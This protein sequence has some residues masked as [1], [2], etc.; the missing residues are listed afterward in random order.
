MNLSTRQTRALG[1]VMHLLTEATDGDAL[2]ESLGLPL[3]DLL[4]ADTYVSMVWNGDER[5]FERMH[6]LNMSAENL[7]A[8]GEY[9]RF[10]D[11]IT[12][13]LMERRRPTLAQQVMPQHELVRTEFFNDFLLRD[14]CYWG[15]N[16]YFYDRDACVGDFR[17][18]R[19]RAR[20]TFGQNELEVLRML[21][22][23]I[24]CTLA[25]LHWRTSQAPASLATEKAEEVLQRKG[26]LSGR[27]AQVAWLV[28]CGCPDKEIC[29]RLGLGYPTVRFHLSNAF[30]KL[31]A[32]NRTALAGRVKAM[33]DD[34][35]AAL[36]G[37]SGTVLA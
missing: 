27:E 15:L 26:R 35:A 22:P 34:R 18:W 23:A 13:P 7:R 2:R 4:D 32:P 30:H 20:G 29:Q 9:F 1:D 21:E 28:S 31:R 10:I 33:L 17:I 6:A 8:W 3:L 14:R 36:A 12:F 37:G 5:C 16:V 19:T 24:A 11:P 25:R